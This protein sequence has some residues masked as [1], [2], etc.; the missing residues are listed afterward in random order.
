VLFFGDGHEVATSGP[1][2]RD[3]IVRYRRIIIVAVIPRLTGHIELALALITSDHNTIRVGQISRPDNVAHCG[4]NSS[5][6]EL[7]IQFS[8][9]ILGQ[10]IILFK[11]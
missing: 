10:E 8:G 5:Y 2:A 1:F 7:G 4:M 11:N 3:A 6:Y 9:K